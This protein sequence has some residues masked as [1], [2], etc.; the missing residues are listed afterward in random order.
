MRLCGRRLAWREVLNGPVYQGDLLTY[1]LQ[2][3]GHRVRAACLASLD[4]AA[5][6]TL[7]DLY[8][9]VLVGI[10]PLALVLRG[11]ERQRGAEGPYSVIQEWHCEVPQ[12]RA[13]P[14]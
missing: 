7:A 12:Q 13:T 6:R 4:P 8:E 1:E 9:P 14:S 11:F 3:S 5:A 2:L 10:A